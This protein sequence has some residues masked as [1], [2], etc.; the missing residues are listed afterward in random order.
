M[1]KDGF[2]Q[3]KYLCPLVLSIKF[4]NKGSVKASISRITISIVPVTMMV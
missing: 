2:N 4:P 3:R 1:I